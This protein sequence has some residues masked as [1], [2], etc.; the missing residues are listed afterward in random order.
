MTNEVNSQSSKI[1]V[2]QDQGTD[3]TATSNP[4]LEANTAKFQ[5]QMA[6]G[7]GKTAAQ[8]SSTQEASINPLNTNISSE[9]AKNKADDAGAKAEKI[10]S[11]SQNLTEHNGNNF[12]HEMKQNSSI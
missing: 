7:G 1:P 6:L 4:E 8:S 11:E 10:L 2:A 3:A 9:S 12:L 5:Q